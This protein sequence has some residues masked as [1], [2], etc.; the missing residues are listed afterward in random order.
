M[1]K[2]RW[3]AWFM[4]SAW[5]I[6]KW[7]EFISGL[8]SCLQQ[9]WNQIHTDRVQFLGQ[10]YLLGIATHSGILAWSLGAYLYDCKELGL[11]EVT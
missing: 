4:R 7:C 11:T 10:E 6:Y 1:I 2:H 9:H 8:V 5:R 3:K